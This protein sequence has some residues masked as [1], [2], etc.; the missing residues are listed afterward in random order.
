MQEWHLFLLF[1]LGFLIGLLLIV[2]DQ[3]DH[4]DGDQ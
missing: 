1:L 4:T 2:G 3:S